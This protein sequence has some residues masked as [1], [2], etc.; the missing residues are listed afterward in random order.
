MPL[1]FTGYT[2]SYIDRVNVGFAKL[3][4][5]RDLK[6]SNTEYGIGAGIF[7]L[8]YFVFEVPANMLL[9]RLGARLWLSLIMMAWGLISTATMFIRDANEFYVAR[10]L[11]GTIEAGFFPGVILYLTYWYTERYRA[12]ITA[13]FMSAIPLS[14]VVSGAVSGWILARM[15]QVGGLHGWQWLFL[16]EG[17]PPFFIGILTYMFLSIRPQDARWLRPEQKEL[18]ARLLSSE[19]RTKPADHYF[20]AFKSPAV[21]WLC[22]I[23]FGLVTASYGISF[24]LPQIVSEILSRNPLRLGLLSTI[25]WGTGV[26]AMIAGGDIPIL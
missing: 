6:M 2:F 17:L 22:A 23:F 19:G 8:G 3:Q 1:L 14:G 16:I 26:I 7:F 25:P 12:R 15:S 5:A 24:W 13:M 21:W 18:L 20:L 9:E 10:F 4:M 11:L